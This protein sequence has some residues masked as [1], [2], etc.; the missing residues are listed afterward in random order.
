M[1]NPSFYDYDRL[2]T[3]RNTGQNLCFYL[4]HP[5]KWIRLVGVVV[6]LDIYPKRWIMVLDDSSGLT[7]EVT[8]ARPTPAVQNDPTALDGSTLNRNDNEP[9]QGLSA[10]GRK[11]DLTGIDIGSL[12]KVK[13]CIATFRGERQLSLER[14]FNIHTTNGEVDSWAENSSFYADILG[15]PWIVNHL[16]E[17]RAKR[18]AEGLDRKQQILAER[19]RR[20]HHDAQADR[21]GRSNDTRSLA[22]A[23]R[24]NRDAEAAKNVA[25]TTAM[26]EVEVKRLEEK[27]YR[28]RE[29]ERLKSAKKR[30]EQEGSNSVRLPAAAQEKKIKIVAAEDAVLKVVKNP[31][32]IKKLEEKRFRIQEYERLQSMKQKNRKERI[33]ISEN[34]TVDKE[35]EGGAGAAKGIAQELFQSE[36]EAKRLRESHLRTQAPER[37]KS[38]MENRTNERSKRFRYP[39][40]EQGDLLGAGGVQDAAAEVISQTEVKRLKEKQFRAQEFE[41]LRLMKEKQKE[42]AVQV[43]KHRHIDM[44]EDRQRSYHAQQRTHEAHMRDV[45]RENV[46]RAILRRDEE[47]QSRELEFKR[48]NGL[49]DLERDSRT[50]ANG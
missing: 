27:Q 43:V 2:L 24:D 14:I 5:I 12:V 26:A 35:N 29:Y 38:I 19:K 13:G 4:N 50:L 6:A 21:V 40:S 10:T 18:K 34:P 11:I 15:K 8:C 36:A 3:L 17:R 45:A 42:N 22:I 25:Q 41:K 44:V 16:E 37:Q 46:E 33:Q 47:K 39:P 9:V 20:K 49:K 28:A 7:L 48:L 32:Q 30:P 1:K 23:R 31:A